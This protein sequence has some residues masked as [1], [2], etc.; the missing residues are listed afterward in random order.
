MGLELQ[1]GLCDLAARSAALN[2]LDVR[3]LC[4]D[5]R[6]PSASL[7]RD[8]DLVV[9]NP[10]YFDASA[11]HLSPAGERALA[12]HDTTC[13]TPDLAR[14]AKRLLKSNGALCVVYPSARLAGLMAALDA[15]SL[16]PTRLRFVHP[17]PGEPAGVVM[18]EAR[19]HARRPL[20]VEAPFVVRP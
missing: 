19:P 3:M 12:R 17:S 11:G 18:V 1:P 15:E 20:V 5:L 6:E 16:V 7:G 8:F 9:S 13:T 10:P 14:A 4:G 2:G